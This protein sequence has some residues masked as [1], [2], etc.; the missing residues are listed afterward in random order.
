MFYDFNMNGHYINF[1]AGITTV[2]KQYYQQEWQQLPYKIV[3]NLKKNNKKRNLS[4]KSKY[5]DNG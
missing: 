5:S 1:E 3:L 2:N 4:N